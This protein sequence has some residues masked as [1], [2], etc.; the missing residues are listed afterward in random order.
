MQIIICYMFKD[1]P[2]IDS[3][4]CRNSFMLYIFKPTRS[5]IKM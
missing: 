2:Y 1:Y 4:S 3:C 5:F